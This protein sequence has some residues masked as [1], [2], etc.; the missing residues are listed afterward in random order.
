LYNSIVA[1]LKSVRNPESGYDASR[2]LEI[3]FA[4][5]GYSY[6]SE[7]DAEWEKDL[8]YFAQIGRQLTDKRNVQ[9]TFRE[10]YQRLDDRGLRIHQMADALEQAG[11][12][13]APFVFAVQGGGFIFGYHMFVS[14]P[15]LTATDRGAATLYNFN[16]HVHSELQVLANVN[17]AWNCRAPGSVDPLGFH[18]RA[19]QDEASRYA[20]GVRHSDFLYG[21][22][23]DSA[24][25]RLYGGEAAPWMAAL[26]RLERDK[27]PILAVPAW[28]DYQWKNAGFDWRAQAERNLQ[29]KPLV[30]KAM[31]ACDTDAKADLVWLAKCLEV[32]TR[33]CRL[34][35]VVYRQKRPR[36]EIEAQ[37]ASILGWMEQSFPFQVTEPDGGDPGLW[38]ALVKR[39][40]NGP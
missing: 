30:D 18:G 35:D 27:G 32:A 15:V 34:C 20:A 23:L 22:F 36:A 13:R 10:Q 19:L 16:G 5:P 12:P 8:K 37:A 17:Y 25:A 40:A 1:E 4:S 24:C 33:L 14:S 29:A 11:W 21:R 28:I 26:F 6:S 31:A 2:D 9:I 7:S 3:V 38:R 39:I